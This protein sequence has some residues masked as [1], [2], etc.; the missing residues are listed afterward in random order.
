[1]PR[2]EQSLTGRGLVCDKETAATSGQPVRMCFQ[3][4][5]KRYSFSLLLCFCSRGSSGQHVY[6]Y[7][8]MLQYSLL[9]LG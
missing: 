2:Y 1:M 6:V 7:Y 4:V 3:S 5:L 9:S 8:E